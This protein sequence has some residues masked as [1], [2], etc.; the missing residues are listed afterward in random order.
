M[1]R[2]R[3]DSWDRAVAFSP[4][5]RGLGFWQHVA[6]T[7]ISAGVSDE[8]SSV[9]GFVGDLLFCAFGGSCCEH[10]W[11][12]RAPAL[13]GRVVSRWSNYEP[14]GGSRSP[15]GRCSTAVSALLL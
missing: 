15:H 13:A 11:W 1:I 10:R 7:L 12:P 6:V 3:T 4:L 9:I 2:N 8:V 5:W 14:V